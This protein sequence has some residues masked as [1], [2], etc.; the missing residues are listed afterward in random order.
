LFCVDYYPQRF[1][2]HLG[3]RP[4]DLWRNDPVVR[5]GLLPYPPSAEDLRVVMGWTDQR[6][7]TRRGVQFEHLLYQCDDLRALRGQTVLIKIDPRDLGCVW[8]V[9]PRPDH[10]GYVA[11]PAANREYAA[12]VSLWQHRVV[13]HMANID[14]ARDNVGLLVETKAGIQMIVE[15]EWSTTRRTRS[16]Q[17]LA[18]WMNQ[19]SGPGVLASAQRAERALA[20]ATQ[21]A[22]LSGRRAPRSRAVHTL[23]QS[24]GPDSTGA[25]HAAVNPV[26]AHVPTLRTRL[27]SG[28]GAFEVVYA[29][30]EVD[31]AD[32]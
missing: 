11:V 10:R 22:V 2:R 6:L 15:R 32:D 20:E 9:D 14:A 7:V 3:G 21:P 25:V 17:V 8:V 13:C 4:I 5:E 16:R 1:N 27:L 18:R 29:H 31:V 24:S 23:P 12:G 26:K 19:Q 30:E 28:R